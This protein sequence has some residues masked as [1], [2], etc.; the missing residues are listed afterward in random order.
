MAIES[1]T[2]FE[3]STESDV[4]SYG[5]VLWELFSFGDVP[6]PNENWSKAFVDMLKS[7]LRLE[8][9]KDATVEV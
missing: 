6:Y 5:V 1:L 9:P 2:G 7:G 8:Q 4:W 3:F